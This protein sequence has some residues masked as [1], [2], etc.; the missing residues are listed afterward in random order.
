MILGKVIG[1]VVS[2]VKDKKYHGVKL[3]IVQEINIKG[4]FEGNF[5]VSADLIGVGVDE[6]VMVVNG[7]AARSS[8]ETKDKGIDSIIVAKIDKLIFQ[9][10][11]IILE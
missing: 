9:D 2:V 7:T 5:Y 10:K 11:E 6:V 8:E 4:E 1:N 3:L